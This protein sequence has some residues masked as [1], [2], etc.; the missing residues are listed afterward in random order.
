LTGD[1]GEIDRVLEL[2]GAPAAEKGC[3][4]ELA[5]LAE[6]LV[7]LFDFTHHLNLI[8]RRIKREGGRT[9]PAGG[10]I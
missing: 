9:I 5:G 10:S 6:Q 2:S 4:L 1:L 8:E 7:P 3:D